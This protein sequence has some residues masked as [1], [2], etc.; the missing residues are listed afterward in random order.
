MASFRDPKGSTKVARQTPTD[1][2]SQRTG[3][4]ARPYLASK[5]GRDFDPRAFLATIGEGRKTTLFL[6]KQA[7]FAQGGSRRRSVLS[8][9]RQDKT[10]R[11]L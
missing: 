3:N 11:C 4:S 8:A 10:H 5:N 1:R 2:I 7:V 6:K 9:D